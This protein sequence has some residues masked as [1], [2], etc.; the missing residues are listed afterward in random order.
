MGGSATLV[1][2]YF[3]SENDRF[4][5]I[6]CY[7]AMVAV[8]CWF[9]AID[10]MYYVRDLQYEPIANADDVMRIGMQRTRGNKKRTMSNNPFVGGGDER[11]HFVDEDSADYEIGYDNQNDQRMLIDQDEWNYDQSSAWNIPPSDRGLSAYD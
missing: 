7:Y 8:M 4:D 11:P 1:S 3:Y 6:V 9:I 2:I 10:G 5:V